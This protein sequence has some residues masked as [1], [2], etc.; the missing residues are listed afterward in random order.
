MSDTWEILRRRCEQ[1][2]DEGMEE[3]LEILRIPSISSQGLGRTCAYHMEGLFR[4]DGWQAEVVDLGTPNPAVLASI[5][6]G[7]GPPAATLLIYGHY[8]VQPPEP[9]EPWLSPPFEPDIRDGRIYARGSAD[10]KAQ[11]YCHIL[12]VRAIRET[13]CLPVR[14]KLILDGE[15]EMGS[16]TMADLVSL[17]H[18]ALQA[19][20]MLTADG[21][22]HPSGRPVVTFGCR[23]VAELAIRVRT[24]NSDRHSGNFGNLHPN[25]AQR[26]AQILAEIKGPDGRVRVPGFYDDIVP[27]TAREREALRAIPFDAEQM[28]RSFGAVALDG[29][30]DVHPMERLMF[31]P[32]FNVA[33]MHSGYTGP[34]FQTVIPSEAVAYID[35]RLAASQDPDKMRKAVADFVA[36]IAPEATVEPLGH[37]YLPART[38]METELAQAVIAGVRTGFGQEPLLYPSVGA[39]GPKAVFVQ[40]LGIPSLTVPYGNADEMN[41]APNENMSIA[42][43]HAGVRTTAAIA[44]ELAGGKHR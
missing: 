25:A 7:G 35:I 10:N 39:S 6:L 16:P 13:L 37:P 36:K 33:G 23:G 1:S 26:L 27:P 29:P 4:R 32:T 15:E 21:G 17:R 11:F 44:C 8:D 43:M 5:D 38:P 9:L 19:D 20:L 42:C 22:I 12:A 31:L 2:V 41:H 30:A 28:R 18:D 3:L 14:V 24:G 40:G 34:G